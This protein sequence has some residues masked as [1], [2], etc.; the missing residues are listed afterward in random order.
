MHC[1]FCFSVP[2]PPA[3][4]VYF[5]AAGFHW[6][7]LHVTLTYLFRRINLRYRYWT[8]ENKSEVTLTPGRKWN[9]FTRC[10]SAPFNPLSDI[11]LTANQPTKAKILSPWRK[12]NLPYLYRWIH[13]RCIQVDRYSQSYLECW[14]SR[15]KDYIV[16]CLRHTRQ[17][18]CHR[19]SKYAWISCTVMH[20]S[21]SNDVEI[22]ETFY[23]S[24][25]R[26]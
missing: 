11:M 22:T 17:C 14:Y 6:T 4:A 12:F 1:F 2:L 15:L 8:A 10:H 20:G 7:E 5:R 23:Y 13:L 24:G 18:L 3:L 16:R 19:K 9:I 21:K 25:Q 26:N